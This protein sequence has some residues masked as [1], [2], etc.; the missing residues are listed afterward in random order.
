MKSLAIVI[1]ALATAAS[2]TSPAELLSPDVPDG[3][4]LADGAATDLTFEEYAPLAP[5]ATSHVDAT[6]AEA[7]SMRA[8]VDVWT[9]GEG[10]ILLREV[11]MWTT[12]EAARAFIEQALVVGTENELDEAVAPFEGGVAF[13]GADEGLWTRTLT[14]RQGPYGITV[15][16]F[17]IEEG[18]DRTLGEAADSLA[19]D[20]ETQTDH[21]IAASGVRSE[22]TDAADTSATNGG[23]PIGTVLIWLVVAA[24]AIWS[25]MTIRRMI[26]T[27]ARSSC[28]PHPSDGTDDG[29]DDVDELIETARVRGRAER[30]I[31]A[32][33]D[34]NDD[35]TPS[36]ET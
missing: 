28:E 6:S 17:A 4:E 30:E 10:D 2:V 33:P 21:G 19:A 23:I 15:S 25:L 32:I 34:P 9:A 12:D 31:E 5:E 13:F 3:F 8:A 16:H 22:A 7:R 27:R 18:T 11:T 26:V 20:I 1:A 24:G 14:W 29:S 36:R 35:R